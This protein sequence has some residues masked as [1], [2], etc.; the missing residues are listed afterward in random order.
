MLVHGKSSPLVTT[1]M[2]L[3]FVG[4]GRTRQLV[5]PKMDYLTGPLLA[6]ELFVVG[7]IIIKAIR[8]SARGT[9]GAWKPPIQEHPSADELTPARSATAESTKIE[10]AQRHTPPA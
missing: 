8:D 10:T 9:G 7:S 5:Q 1:R 3:Y 6:L 2:K 4:N